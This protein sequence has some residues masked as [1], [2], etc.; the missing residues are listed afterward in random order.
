MNNKCRR[1]RSGV[2]NMTLFKNY[3]TLKNK[4]GGNFAALNL[5]R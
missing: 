1:F 3:I 4:N 5:I 2:N